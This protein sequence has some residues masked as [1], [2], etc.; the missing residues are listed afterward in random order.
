M[1]NRFENEKLVVF[2]GIIDVLS[3]EYGTQLT[4]APDIQL[5]V[6]KFSELLVDIYISKVSKKST[7]SYLL[8]NVEEMGPLD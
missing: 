4:D 3:E 1:E 5:A 7:N 8:D 6:R 2:N